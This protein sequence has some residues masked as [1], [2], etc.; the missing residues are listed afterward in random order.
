MSP[1]PIYQLFNNTTFGITRVIQNAMIESTIENVPSQE[2]NTIV[3]EGFSD[4]LSVT[5]TISGIVETKLYVA[6][7]SDVIPNI[8]SNFSGFGQDVSG[9]TIFIAR[10]NK[11]LKLETIYRS[12][13]LNSPNGKESSPKLVYAKKKLFIVY[14][15]KGTVNNTG[16][17][18]ADRV[19]GDTSIDLVIAG[20]N[21]YNFSDAQETIAT[22]Y[23]DTF[24]V[25]WMRQQ[26]TFNTH[27]KDVME[28]SIAFDLSNNILYSSFV[29]KISD[30]DNDVNVLATLNPAGKFINGSLQYGNTVVLPYLITFAQTIEGQSSGQSTTLMGNLNTVNKEYSPAIAVD[31]FSRLYLIY[32]TDATSGTIGTGGV[33]TTL[34]STS[35]RY[36]LCRFTPPQ[37]LIN[38]APNSVSN[39]WTLTHIHNLYIN[40]T[41]NASSNNNTQTN[42]DM[43]YY[44]KKLYI[45]TSMYETGSNGTIPIIVTADI[46]NSSTFILSSNPIVGSAT[47]TT[48]GTIGNPKAR[49]AVG[50]KDP[51]GNENVYLIYQLFART[52]LGDNTLYSNISIARY[53]LSGGVFSFADY[54]A[55]NGNEG[56]DLDGMNIPGKNAVNPSVAVADGQIIIAYDTNGATYYYDEDNMKV[57][58]RYGGNTEINTY[59]DLVIAKINPFK[60]NAPKGITL[61]EGIKFVELKWSKDIIGNNV[62]NTINPSGSATW[63]PPTNGS[64]WGYRISVRKTGEEGADFID[65]IDIIDYDSKYYSNEYEEYTVRIYN[66]DYTGSVTG[67]QIK[68]DL[69]PGYQFE[70]NIRAV[71]NDAVG[72]DGIISGMPV[73]GYVV[74]T[75]IGTNLSKYLPSYRNAILGPKNPDD[76]FTSDQF[77]QSLTISGLIAGR[78]IQLAVRSYVTLTN[79]INNYSLTDQSGIAI[80][81]YAAPQNVTA[82]GTEGSI[83]VS[84]NAVTGENLDGY[85]IEY[86]RDN[87]VNT[88]ST[89]FPSQL[90]NGNTTLS[91]YLVYNNKITEFNDLPDNNSSYT[92]RVKAVGG[93]NISSINGIQLSPI[94]GY[95]VIGVTSGTSSATPLAVSVD[96]TVSG[97]YNIFEYSSVDNKNILLTW[98]NSGSDNTISGHTIIVNGYRIDIPSNELSQYDKFTKLFIGFSS[99]GLLGGVINSNFGD[100]PNSGLTNFDLCGSILINQNGPYSE[101]TNLPAITFTQSSA[102]VYT[103]GIQLDKVG[104][105][106]TIFNNNFNNKF[107]FTTWINIPTGTT[108]TEIPLF[109]TTNDI[110]ATNG[111]IFDLDRNNTGYYFAR[112]RIRN[113]GTI[114]TTTF[115][116]GTVNNIVSGVWTH[117]GIVYDEG[118]CHLYLNGDRKMSKYNT[119]TTIPSGNVLF[120]AKYSNTNTSRLPIGSRLADIRFYSYSLIDTVVQSI[121]FDPNLSTKN[122]IIPTYK[123]YLLNNTIL[124]QLDRYSYNIPR[125]TIEPASIYS[126]Q[127]FAYNANNNPHGR[128]I[129][130]KVSTLPES[131]NMSNISLTSFNSLAISTSNT[132]WPKAT[133]SYEYKS[134]K[135]D[136]YNYIRFIIPRVSTDGNTPVDSVV[137]QNITI[138]GFVGTDPTNEVKFN[139][140]DNIT[141]SSVNGSNTADKAFDANSTTYYQSYTDKYNSF[142]AYVG[143]EQ[144][145]V[146]FYNIT[147]EWV[148]VYSTTGIQINN[149]LINAVKNGLEYDTRIPK[150]IIIVGSN[151]GTNWNEIYSK[152]DILANGEFSTEYITLSNIGLNPTTDLS[153]F[154]VYYKPR[155][156]SFVATP[157]DK[158]SANKNTFS[159]QTNPLYGGNLYNYYLTA[160]VKTK[161]QNDT[162]YKRYI[163]MLNNEST[164]ELTHFGEITGNNIK[165]DIITPPV[166]NAVVLNIVQSKFQ[167][168]LDLLYHNKNITSYVVKRYNSQSDAQNNTNVQSSYTYTDLVDDTLDVNDPGIMSGNTY[169]FRVAVNAGQPST[170]YLFAFNSNFGKELIVRDISNIEIVNV[171]GESQKIKIYLD[172]V[173]DPTKNQNVLL[174]YKV[175]DATNNSFTTKFKRIITDSSMVELKGLFPKR[176]ISNITVWLEEVYSNTYEYY[177]SAVGYTYGQ[178][179]TPD[180]YLPYAPTITSVLPNAANTSV[181]AQTATITWSATKSDVLYI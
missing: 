77:D 1:R 85:I 154:N 41:N 166:N 129:S 163:I 150:D 107:T 23:K 134:V 83:K 73:T 173:L 124:S 91:T 64:K 115:D 65:L 177:R 58:N 33:T 103:D 180:F 146:N 14:T 108:Q 26:S 114:Y 47:D 168:I 170:E 141:A 29:K 99:T 66:K 152:F 2:L 178:V 122:T 101:N 3:G 20:M 56:T 36:I 102:G 145:L 44:N 110:T 140:F 74:N 169:Y 10:F 39:W 13:I 127:I 27:A 130:R 84:W 113:N 54:T 174:R 70:Y 144:T 92:V 126:I 6:Y 96:Y 97:E 49:L 147:G 125:P 132:N 68:T 50:L 34:T 19:D 25:L 106:R 93:S 100:S 153:G 86:S 78:P 95:R 88:L 32:K 21:I 98:G 12:P 40:N 118:A 67:N 7:V 156:E 157:L 30:T 48:T 162:F 5:E 148:Q 8:Y 55:A 42:I 165:S 149:I 172:K 138:C 155:H 111:L 119:V 128:I 143:T 105:T 109:A 45:G 9:G 164:N 71:L 159:I 57:Q 160:S 11:D 60:P 46:P 31:E 63:W 61:R 79:T 17:N 80:P 181:S 59:N 4:I 121:R 51:N 158:V 38:N 135:K 151:D 53:S 52:L 22:A 179:V 176:D 76:L 167:V 24:D 123:K 75:L 69:D 94:N 35:G 18:F 90:A 175:A 89:F 142:G 131:P 139:S 136:Y 171:I 72:D 37:D 43:V 116:I 104:G 15:T 81:R 112:L 87:F 82:I 16:N 120:I 133:I 161:P 62:D 117:I 137:I 28:L